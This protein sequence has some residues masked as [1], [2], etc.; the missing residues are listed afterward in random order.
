MRPIASI[1]IVL[2]DILCLLS[3]GATLTAA[4]TSGERAVPLYSDGG[5]GNG[6]LPSPPPSH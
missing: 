6:L 5:S 3:N 4:I 2:L 1:T